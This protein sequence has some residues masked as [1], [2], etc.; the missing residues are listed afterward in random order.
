LR[1]RPVG[2]IL[3][4]DEES[5]L[6]KTTDLTVLSKFHDNHQK[7]PYY[8]KPRTSAPAFGV[9]HYAGDVIYQITGFL[10]KNKDPLRADVTEVLQ[11]SR[12]QFIQTLFQPSEE[13]PGSPVS[14]TMSEG[15]GTLVRGANK[16]KRKP[17]TGY[18]FNNSLTELVNTLTACNPL[19]VRCIKPNSVKKSNL[20]DKKMVLAQ[21]RYSGMLETIRIRRAGFSCRITFDTFNDRYRLLAVGPK[22]NPIQVSQ[23]IVSAANINAQWA[24]IGK[25]KVFLKTEGE[26]ALENARAK[27]IEKQVVII[28]AFFRMLHQRMAYLRMKQKIQLTQRRIRGY[29]VRWRVKQRR[30]GVLR[31]QSCK[32]HTSHS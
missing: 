8:I 6:P 26:A 30:V 17:S 4:L 16:S 15:A 14:P 1:Q 22:T 25:S 28:Q 23:N 18:Q 12:S 20:I 24:R 3:L 27:R 21:L 32:D 31:L 11:N 19:F 10:D 13:E 5:N 7:N 29:L 9:K 2:L